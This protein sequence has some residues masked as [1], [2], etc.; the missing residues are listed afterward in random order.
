MHSPSTYLNPA[1]GRVPGVISAAM[2]TRL[3]RGL[4]RPGAGD[5]PA[6]GRQM[7]Q[8]ALASVD[9]IGPRDK[10]EATL[11]TQIPGLMLA[12]QEIEAEARVEPNVDRRIRMQKHMMAL[13]RR[14]EGLGAELRRHR[15]G[16]AQQDLQHVSPPAQAYDLDALEAVWQQPERALAEAV[17]VALPLEIPPGCFGMPMPGVAPQ[18]EVALV[19]LDGKL[20]DR[21]EFEVDPR[22]RFQGVPL[23]KQHGKKYLDE[24]DAEELGELTVAQLE[25]GEVVEEPPHR[26][27]EWSEP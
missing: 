10:F 8:D 20:E 2:L 6:M 13:Q 3:L 9:A 1:L 19:G 22:P 25:R 16:L 24:L 26:P 17:L 4:P 5:L 21:D 18:A 14:A 11:V 15:R 23:W 12:A 27:V 7:I